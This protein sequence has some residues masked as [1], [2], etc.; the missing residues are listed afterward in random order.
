MLRNST[1]VTR[2]NL[3]LVLEN[4]RALSYKMRLFV[5]ILALT[6][7]L[8]KIMSEEESKDII[9]FLSFS[10][11]FFFTIPFLLLRGN[12]DSLL[13]TSLLGG[14]A[15]YFLKRFIGKIYTYGTIVII[16]IILFFSYFIIDKKRN[17]G[18]AEIVIT[19]IIQNGNFS[20]KKNSSNSHAYFNIAEYPDILFI[21]KEYEVMHSFKRYK[22][23]STIDA[24]RKRLKI[25]DTVNFN[26]GKNCRF[27]VKKSH[28]EWYEKPFIK[29]WKRLRYP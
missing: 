9:R 10:L 6:N 2:S 24:S 25:Y 7:L 28:L 11:L 22:L 8:A 26:T 21:S 1:N 20:R 3:L 14:L 23:D 12:L 15:I 27:I 29:F 4:F 19:G 17:Y 18:S 5:F 13:I 16:C